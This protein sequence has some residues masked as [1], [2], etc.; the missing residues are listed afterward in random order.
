MIMGCAVVPSVLFWQRTGIAKAKRKQ[1]NSSI[2]EVKR[3]SIVE[4]LM[5]YEKEEVDG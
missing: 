5:G 1:I 4:A 3:S 2:A